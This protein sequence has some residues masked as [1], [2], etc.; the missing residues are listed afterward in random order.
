MSDDILHQAP[1]GPAAEPAEVV[2]PGN[3]LETT[4]G[5]GASEQVA[6]TPEQKAEREKVALIDKRERAW[7]NQREAFKRHMDRGDRLEQQNRELMQHI[8]GMQQ[9]KQQ[10]PA[11]PQKDGPPKREQF[12]SYEAYVDARAEWVADQ[13]TQE[14]FRRQE[15]QAR[16]ERQQQESQSIEHGHYSRVQEFAQSSPEMQ[17]VMENEDVSVPVVAGEAIK[18]M[19]DGPAILLAMHRE[20]ALAEA[21]NRMA[22]AEQFL[23]LGQLSAALRLRP[24]QFSKAPAPGTPVGSKSSA[25]VTLENAS[26]E[27]F[28]KIRRKQI[29]ARRR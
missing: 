4:E 9:G 26:Y 2:Q 11:Q 20:P 29:A 24:P 16:Q 1:T 17:A 14:H 7:R 3:V 25:P 13:R 18:R 6:E 22:P 10:Q 19:A 8:L 12:E 5:T 15:Q 23:Y 21:L 28:V 27:D